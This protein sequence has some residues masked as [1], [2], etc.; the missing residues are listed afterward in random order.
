MAR[1][2]KF[3]VA[4]LAGTLGVAL[5]GSDWGQGFDPDEPTGGM[6]WTTDW[7]GVSSNTIRFILQGTLDPPQSR[8]K[9]HIDIEDDTLGI[10]FQTRD[11]TGPFITY[12]FL[13]VATAAPTI[14]T[15]GLIT[16]GSISGQITAIGLVWS[17]YP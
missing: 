10:V 6:T 5:N 14:D 13:P 1:G 4:G 3:R 11:A 9:Y 15:P 17:E 7:V 12:G 16:H 8:I 2:Y